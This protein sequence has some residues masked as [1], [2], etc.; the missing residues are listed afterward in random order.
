LLLNAQV[1]KPQNLPGY[2]YKRL[3]FGFTFG[4]NT[5]DMG[6]KRSFV[7]DL[8]PDISSP[9][10]GINVSIVS[11]LR[12][13]ENLN[14]R[15]LPGIAL[16]DR[17]F[18]FY[19]G[20]TLDSRMTL[21]ASYLD[22]PLLLKYSGKRLNNVKPYV[23]G[24]LNFRY[25]M[26]SKKEYNEGEDVFIRLKPADLYLEIGMGLD[27]YLT[28]FKFSTELKLGVGMLNVV[29]EDPAQGHPQYVE[30]I[31]KLNSFIVMLNFH[32]E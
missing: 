23:I 26:A 27:Y 29:V 5:M 21:D 24:G 22:F 17:T 8:Y 16:G 25:D 31:N 13:T 7:S 9:G 12:L 30:S 32:F 2:D 20:D 4:I 28:F 10:A 14:L 6:M 19:H 1:K 18:S 11:D 3:R 15:F